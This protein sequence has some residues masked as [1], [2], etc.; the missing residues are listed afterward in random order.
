MTSVP[1]ENRTVLNLSPGPYLDPDLEES[2]G[3]GADETA[4][5]STRC[6]IPLPAAVLAASMAL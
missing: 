5:G 4:G 3:L 2:L 1:T 6:L